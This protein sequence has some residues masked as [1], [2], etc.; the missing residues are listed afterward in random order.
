MKKLLFYITLMCSL[1][2]LFTSCALPAKQPQPWRGLHV[3]MTSRDKT[4]QLTEVEGRLADVGI[5]VIIAEINYGYEYDSHPR[6]RAADPSSKDQIRKLVAECRKHHIRLI[7]Q[8]QCLGHQSWA[9]HTYPLLVEY[10]QFDETPGRYPDNEGIYSRSWCPLHPQ[11]NPIIFDLMDELV[12]AFQADA[13]HI[14]M[15][16][17]FLIGADSCLRCKG[18]DK[19]GLFAAAVNDYHRHLAGKHN[20]E[21]LM[22]GDRLIDA[23]KIDYGTWEASDNDTAGAINLI[24]KDIIICDWHYEPRD[25]YESIPLFLEKGFRVWPAGWRKLQAT[26]ALLEYSQSLNNT[27][28]LGHLNTTWGTVPIKDLPDFKPLLYVTGRLK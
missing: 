1:P 24:P 25:T 27:N 9:K 8:F 11:V 23:R 10:P 15:D 14:G 19:A 18:K 28:M 26:K 7:P 22:W 5:N 21:M 4:E 16:E 17:V 20:L 2:V 6:L 12:D 3:L 13:F